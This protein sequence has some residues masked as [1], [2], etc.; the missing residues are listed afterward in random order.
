MKGKNLL[1]V[2]VSQNLNRCH[3]P[4]MEGRAFCKLHECL[5]RHCSV[6]N[7]LLIHPHVSIQWH[8]PPLLLPHH[9]DW[10]FLLLVLH[11]DISE[12]ASKY[13]IDGLQTSFL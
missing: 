5:S 6:R 8:R 3:S 1:G 4:E 9:A 2:K 11:C 13:D 12:K 7:G 10:V